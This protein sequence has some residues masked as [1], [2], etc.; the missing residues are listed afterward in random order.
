MNESWQLSYTGTGVLSN[1]PEMP[2]N[3]EVCWKITA[4]CELPHLPLMHDTEILFACEK[5]G[6]FIQH[7]SDRIPLGNAE[8]LRVRQY[9]AGQKLPHGDQ[10]S[11]FEE[12][13]SLPALELEHGDKFLL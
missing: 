5:P 2:D 1:V 11:G 8:A 12:T 4:A 9:V 10:E 7:A 13:L 6:D 3:P